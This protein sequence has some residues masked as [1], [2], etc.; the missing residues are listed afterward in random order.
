MKI[1]LGG[2]IHGC[3]D[4][5]CK[6]WRIHVKSFI[7]QNSLETSWE[8]IDPMDYDYRGIEDDNYRKIVEDDKAGILESDILLVNFIK[9]SVGTSM[10]I[11]FAWEQHK[12]VILVIG[13]P[14][15]MS[16]WLLYHSRMLFY[17]LDEALNY[18][19][20]ESLL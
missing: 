13:S 7:K 12:T 3:S 1:Y 8:V 18:I 19:C 2:P 10:E 15:N 5:E 4:S 11:L 9:P 17:T 16:P 20:E 14:A 6:D